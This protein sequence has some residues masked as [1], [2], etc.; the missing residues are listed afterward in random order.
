ML[1]ITIGHWPFSDQFQ[2]L[3]DQNPFWLAKFPIA[4]IS[5]RQQSIAYKI[6][7][8]QTTAD[9]F[10]ILIYS[11]NYMPTYSLLYITSLP[12]AVLC[13][14]KINVYVSSC[15]SVSPYIILVTLCLYLL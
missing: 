7:Y 1:E 4:T 3:A 13:H 2:H 8:L 12:V 6:S 9:Q 10:L 5:M 14:Y 15:M 11:T